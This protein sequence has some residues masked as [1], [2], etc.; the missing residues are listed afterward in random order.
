MRVVSGTQQFGKMANKTD[1]AVALSLFIPCGVLKPNVVGQLFVDGDTPLML[2]GEI[3]KVIGTTKQ[4]KV[5]FA[6][7]RRC[8]RPRTV[9][10]LCEAHKRESDMGAVFDLHA[11]PVLPV[12]KHFEFEG[13]E[14]ALAREAE[15][16]EQ[17]R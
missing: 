16:K 4:C 11:G 12:R 2:D 8:S 14:D 1:N 3:V 13:D 5:Y 7:G 15:R 9:G 10:G 17:R 6:D